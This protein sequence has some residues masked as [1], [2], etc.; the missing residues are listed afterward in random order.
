MADSSNTGAIARGFTLD[1]PELWVAFRNICFGILHLF[2]FIT[3]AYVIYL[4]MFVVPKMLGVTQSVPGMPMTSFVVLLVHAVTAVPPLVI[5]LVA[6]NPALRRRSMGT[7]RFL[8]KLYCY[9]IWISSVTGILLATGN[10]A[11]LGAQLGFGTLGLVW[12]VT[13]TFAYRTGRAKK[14]PAH[15]IWMI[16]SYAT[17]L[18]VVTVRPLLWFGPAEG[19]E[20]AEWTVFISWACWIPNLILAEIYLRITTFNGRL[21]LPK[22][23]T[24]KQQQAV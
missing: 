19:F 13:T 11:G 23:R 12:L 7:H 1:W 17:T 10:H 9:C 20:P 16:R 5:G 22:R 14:I 4:F 24:N 3:F 21:A 2:V 8:G 15:R 18:A 6:F